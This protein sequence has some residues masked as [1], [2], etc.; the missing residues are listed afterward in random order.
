M[1]IIATH[2][3]E[4]NILGLVVGPSDGPPV[5]TAVEAGQYQSEVDVPSD[6]D[7]LL[8]AKRLDENRITKALAAY[9]VGAKG[10]AKLVSK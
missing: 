6:I 3:A 1:K 10:K 4:G 7:K 2:D 9:R 5:A 8:K